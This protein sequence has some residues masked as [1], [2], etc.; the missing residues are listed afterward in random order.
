MDDALF[1]LK[2]TYLA[3][4]KAFNEE[5][6]AYGLTSAQFEVL[7]RL[8]HEDGLEQRT[9]QE[10]LGVTP[11][12]LTGVIDGLVE[13]KQLERRVSPD[14][15]RVKQLF[16][17]PQGRALSSCILCIAARYQEQLLTDFT[18]EQISTLRNLLQRLAQNAITIQPEEQAVS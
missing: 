9:L 15:A 12:T 3:V 5:L 13:R 17:T 4:R 14:D 10:C 7:A 1:W 6:C 8:W 2:Q 16:L 18:Q 11:P